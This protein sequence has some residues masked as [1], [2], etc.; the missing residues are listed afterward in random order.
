M[1]FDDSINQY[2]NELFIPGKPSH[3]SIGLQVELGIKKSSNFKKSKY[4]HS[5]R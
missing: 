4:L 1:L 2:R 3:I 5:K